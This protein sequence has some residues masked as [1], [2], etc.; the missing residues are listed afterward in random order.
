MRVLICGSRSWSNARLIWEFLEVLRDTDPDA[1]VIHG[2][3]RGA[4]R[5]AGSAAEALGLKVT[6]VPAE[7]EKFG[8]SAGPMR[9][10]VMLGM[11]PDRVI[12]FRC[13]G[14]SKGTDHMLRLARQARIP[15]RVVDPTGKTYTIG[16][17]RL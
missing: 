1:E 14:E 8:P 6:A 10:K 3:A 7:W 2:D 9:N 15:Y 5:L 16:G 13:E 11:A 12:A 17:I 4:D